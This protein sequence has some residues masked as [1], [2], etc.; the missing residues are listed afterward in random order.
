MLEHSENAPPSHL[1]R[2]S[3]YLKPI[4]LQADG[5]TSERDRRC[6]IPSER[7]RWPEQSRRFQT[8]T[9]SQITPRHLG[10]SLLQR[11]KSSPPSDAPLS[12]ASAGP[13]A[14]SGAGRER[15]LD[16]FPQP[17]GWPGEQG[18]LAPCD[19]SPN[20]KA[21]AKAVLAS[22]FGSACTSRGSFGPEA[23]SGNSA[24]LRS[25][26]ALPMHR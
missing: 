14:G 22:R 5:Q 11:A 25:G 7:S 4:A 15:S 2:C 6:Q 20:I 26:G 1:A 23:G 3:L 18:V 12:R 17:W 10:F 21:K 8:H 13:G 9:E 24:W 16:A 19:A